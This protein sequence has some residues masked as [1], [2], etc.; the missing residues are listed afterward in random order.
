[1]AR[2]ISSVLETLLYRRSLKRWAVAG[3]TAQTVDLE[4]L[5]GWRGRAK[6]LRRLLD[7]LINEADHRLALPLVGSAALPKPLGTD[8]VWRPD[9][10]TNALPKPGMASVPGKARIGEGATLFH[11]C[12]TSELTLRQIRNTRESDIAP[13]GFRVEVFRFEGSFLSLVLDLPDE[14]ARGLKLRHVIRLEANVEM[15]RPLGIF[16]RLNIRHGPNLEQIVRELPQNGAEAM[17]EFDL[18]YSK[19]NEKR[20]EKLW[21]DLIFESP[22][23]NAV[24]LRDVT[25]SRRPR[26]EF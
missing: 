15:E 17:V 2:R 9:L 5:R 3:S 25:L 24:T 16:V 7:Q 12:R 4:T 23:M 26:A 1:M 14:A 21:L 10:W 20:V 13:F 6:A 19:M 8:W 22:R 11:D 18:A